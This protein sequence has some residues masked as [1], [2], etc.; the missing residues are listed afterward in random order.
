MKFSTQ[1]SPTL[2]LALRVQKARHAGRRVLS[3]STPG[4]PHRPMAI[5]A[6][7][8]DGRMASAE[9]NASCREQL[10]QTLF[11]RWSAQPEELVL[12]GGAKSALLCLVATLV[13]RAGRVACFTPAW[14]TYWSLA[15]ALGREP[16][17][18][19]RRLATGWALETGEFSRLREG[20]AVVLSNPCNPTGRV[21]DAREIGALATETERRGLWLLLDESFSATASAAARF[22]E[23][24]ARLGERVV[25]VNSVSKNYLAQGWRLGAILAAQSVRQAFEKVQTALV[26]PPAAPLQEMVHGVLRN[27]VDADFIA[28]RHAIAHARLVA[29]NYECT[30]AQGSFY[31]FPGRRGLAA[32]AAQLEAQHDLYFLDGAAFGLDDP[33]YLRLCVLQP[34]GGLEVVLQALA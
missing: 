13:P 6:M 16:V 26:S 4:F 18:L 11:A 8:L 12:T 21:Y 28:R 22:A 5:P 14:P 24:V 30:P 3:A 34:D 29:M 31:L 25:V 2:E 27:P 19:P 32:R 15:Q 20:D 10:A 7:Q 1:E 23:P 9:G 33:D 17:L